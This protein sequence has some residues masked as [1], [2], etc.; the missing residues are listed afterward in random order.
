MSARP[1]SKDTAANVLDGKLTAGAREAERALVASALRLGARQVCGWSDAES[2]LTRGIRSRGMPR[3]TALREQIRA[4]EDPLG[5]A[6]IQLRSA[7]DRRRV[8]ATYTPRIVVEA[9]LAWAQS[10]PT[11]AQVVDP[12]TGSAR[13]LLHAGAAFPAAHL[14]GVE[15]D[16]LAALIARGN[17]AAAG[18]A[19]RSRVE[20]GD[21]RSFQLMRT[22]RTLF[23]GNPPYVRHHLIEPAW[24]DWL[25]H[26]WRDFG[27]KASRLAGLH[28]HFFLATLINARPGDCGAFV[29]AAEWLDVNYGGALRQSFLERLGGVG[30]V[31]VEPT[32]TTFPGAATTAAITLFRIGSHSN[33]VGVR[34]VRR[35]AD[36]ADLSGRAVPRAAFE[37]ETRWSRLVR[38]TKSFGHKGMTARAA[39]H[40]RA[41]GLIELG[42]LCRVH[43]GQATGANAVWVVS[44]AD[45]IAGKL[46]DA[47]LVPTVTRAR[48]LI[49]AG[50][51]LTD[52]TRL[53]R[54]VDLPAQLEGLD[55][56]TARVVKAFLRAARRRGAHRSY[57]ARH[58]R[59]WWAVGLREPAPILATYMA[60][61]P[62]VFTC[63]PGGARHLNIAHGLYPRAPLTDAQLAL[64]VKYLSG[65]AGVTGGRTYSGGLIKF[66]PRE[67]ERILIP[68]PDER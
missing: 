3:L 23:I 27:V 48:E 21:F 61:R 4:G 43:R 20:L 13:F 59:P 54:V 58:R 6:F 26:R 52:V 36:L 12:G 31:M 67:M 55:V 17:L 47:L 51:V 25:A 68:R 63:N 15:I 56:E 46:P 22:G 66:E 64:L 10:Q 19:A 29:T 16:P 62:P 24:K 39:A 7:A 32:V 53:R 65:S 28:L 14:I 42:E 50:S 35:V 40:R 8:G 44:G 5:S 9:M 1:V 18:L 45:H 49:A 37:A 57:L 2:A 34:C 33:T 41:Q 11:P 30:I 60:R 38:A